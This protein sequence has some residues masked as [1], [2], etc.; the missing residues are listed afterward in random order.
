MESLYIDRR[1]TT[2]N[3]E[4]QRLL[5]HH[6]DA[7][8]PQSVPLAHLR[9]VVISACTS[10]NSN[11]LQALRHA[12]VAQ[13][14]AEADVGLLGGHG[15]G[16]GRRRGRARVIIVEGRLGLRGGGAGGDR[17]EGCGDGHGT[18]AS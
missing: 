5:I 11:V 17:Q 14:E 6:P 13:A 16:G 7:I 10:L 8:R 1:D 15:R 9:F 12:H 2:L 18:S 4:G 3:V